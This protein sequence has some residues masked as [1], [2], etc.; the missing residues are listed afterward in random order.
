MVVSV[1]W[2]DV[3][4]PQLSTFT[5]DIPDRIVAFEECVAMFL[6][7]SAED[8]AGRTSLPNPLYSIDSEGIHY[9]VI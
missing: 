2:T 9:K 7:P 8:A 4:T 3:V 1:L 6:M 5:F